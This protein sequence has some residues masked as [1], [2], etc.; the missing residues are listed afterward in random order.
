MITV[1]LQTDAPPDAVLAVLHEA[2]RYADWVVGTRKIIGVDPAWPAPGSS[3]AHQV[4]LGP[5]HLSD[6][7]TMVADDAGHVILDARAF[8]IGRARVEVRLT[9]TSRGTRIELGEEP[10]SGPA[11]FV[12]RILLDPV[13]R[14]RNTISLERLRGL[15]EGRED[16]PGAR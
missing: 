9:P 6:R 15:A 2:P 7:T 1:S 16:P 12:P 3:F 8:P 13:T 10:V 4:G 5:L 11:R 14:R